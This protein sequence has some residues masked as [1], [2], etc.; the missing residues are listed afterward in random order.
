MKIIVSSDGRGENFKDF[1]TVKTLEEV[2]NYKGIDTIILHKTEEKDFT[3]G[4]VLSNLRNTLGNFRLVYINQEPRAVIQMCL[5]GIGGYSYTDEFYLDDEDELTT[6]LEDIDNMELGNS[7]EDPKNELAMVT[8]SNFEIIFE[9]MRSFARGE[10]RV[11]A[12][13]YQEQVNDAISQLSLIT[14]EQ[15]TQLTTMGSTAMSIFAKASALVER[16]QVM[17]SELDEKVARIESEA[18]KNQRRAPLGGSI[19]FFPPIKY[20]NNSKV[21]VIKEY[22]SCRYLISYI[23]A[24]K[25]WLHILHGKSVRLMIVTGN[26]V[27]PCTKYAPL[28]NLI[29]DSTAGMESLISSDSL[30]IKSPKKDIMNNILDKPYDLTI[31]IDKLLSKDFI[32]DGRVIKLNAVSGA[33]DLDIF[34]LNVA[35]TIFSTDNVDGAFECIKSI[36]NFPKEV[37]GRLSAYNQMCGK[38]SFIK[39]KE[40]VGF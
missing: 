35:D 4:V 20:L 9:F 11:N 3:I 15:S 30:I 37:N 34:K 39:L 12:P 36:E 16:V 26:L 29:S 21:L 22:S 2:K 8:S 33:S 1:V 7:E 5:E 17:Q 19:N 38:S 18:L 31:V 32:L 27:T 24:F 25:H 13:I 14:Q 23:L 28:G 10:E 6:L 40:K